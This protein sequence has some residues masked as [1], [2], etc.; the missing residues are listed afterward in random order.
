[1]FHKVIGLLIGQFKS[2]YF[3]DCTMQPAAS[4]LSLP[5]FS[6]IIAISIVQQHWPPRADFDSAT[7]PSLQA[8]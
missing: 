1:V 8:K 3:N 4:N 6:F 2:A 5:S 7:T